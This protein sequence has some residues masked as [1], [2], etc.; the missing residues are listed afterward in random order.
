M[1]NLFTGDLVKTAI[2]NQTLVLKA[3]GENALLFD[4]K[5]K[6][7]VFAKGVENQNGCVF[8]LQGEYFNQLPLDLNLF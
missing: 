7:Y 2:S 1:T 8:W 3:E 6:K 4:L 5:D